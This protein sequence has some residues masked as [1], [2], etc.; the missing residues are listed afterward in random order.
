MTVKEATQLVIQAGAISKGGEV[1][2]LDM[3]K[4]IKIFDLAVN[5]IN[6]AGL[7]VKDKNNPLGDIEI[8]ITGLRPEKN[9]MR[10]FLFQKMVNLQDIKKFLKLTRHYYQKRF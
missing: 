7:Q 1:F 9:Y 6:T 2:V 10:S 5:M 3:G 8:K 4:P